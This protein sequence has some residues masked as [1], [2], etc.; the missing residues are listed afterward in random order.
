MVPAY[1]GGPARPALSAEQDVVASVLLE[2]HRAVR[3]N[4]L[5]QGYEHY[6]VAAQ[7]DHLSEVAV[8][9]GV[10]RS[11]AEARGEHAIERGW[12]AA[13]LDVTE[14]GGAGLKAGASL[15]LTLELVSD[16]TEPRVTESF[17]AP[18]V[19]VNVPSFGIAP[20]ATTT[21]EK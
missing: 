1:P 18:A 14:H 10:D 15:D 12:R 19:T 2:R 9:D 4:G 8:V 20:S 21:I 11:Q 5:R 13:A 6:L 17:S 16:A 3:R 7:R